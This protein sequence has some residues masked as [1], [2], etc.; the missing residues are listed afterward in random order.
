MILCSFLTVIG[1]TIFFAR[2][3]DGSETSAEL[4]LASSVIYIYVYWDL[5][6]VSFVAG[7]STAIYVFESSESF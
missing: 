6:S 7:K 5:A 1:V 2:T 3:V 4:R